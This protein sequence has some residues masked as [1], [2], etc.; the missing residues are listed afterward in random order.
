MVISGFCAGARVGSAAYEPGAG[1]TVMSYSG[2]CGA[3]NIGDPDNYFAI[4]SVLDIDRYVN[5]DDGASCGTLVA[6]G[7]QAPQID[8]VSA[9]IT[10][11]AHTPFTLVGS[12]SDPDDDPIKYSWQQYNRGP[13]GHPN[14]PTGNAP[15]FRVLPSTS[16]PTRTFPALDDVLDNHQQIGELLPAYS[17]NMRFRLVARDNQVPQGLAT[18]DVIVHVAGDA[19]PL[20]VLQPDRSTQVWTVGST[21]TIVWD[22][23]G[24]DAAPIDC[25]TVNID[26]S[27]DGGQHFAV[28]LASS[29]PNNGNHNI[30]VPNTPT[31]SARL[32][33][34]CATHP[35]HF[36]FAIAAAEFSIETVRGVTNS[37]PTGGSCLVGY[38]T[39]PTMLT[40]LDD[41]F[42]ESSQ[43]TFSWQPPETDDVIHLQISRDPT[44]VDDVINFRPIPTTSYQLP[45]ERALDLDTTYY[46]RIRVDE[47]CGGGAWSPPQTF[48][49]WQPELAADT[50]DGLVLWLDGNDVDGDFSA[51]T[52]HYDL[53]PTWHDKSVTAGDAISA[54]PPYAGQQPN[55]GLGQVE[56]L[57][58]SYLL[59]DSV[60]TLTNTI[61][62]TIFAVLAPSPQTEGSLIALSRSTPTD[63]V[64]FGLLENGTEIGINATSN[65]TGLFSSNA[66][67]LSAP[68]LRSDEWLLASYSTSEIPDS[69]GYRSR[70]AL[71]GQTVA[72]DS[73][74][75]G[76]GDSGGDRLAVGGISADVGDILVFDRQLTATE[77]QQV[78]GY[79]AHKW[80]LADRLPVGHPYAENPHLISAATSRLLSPQ[81]PLQSA[82]FCRVG[83]IIG[84]VS[85]AD[86]DT[87]L[88]IHNCTR[89]W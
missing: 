60:A 43:P 78:E 9:E 22:V 55:S 56:L 44:F 35:D 48:R 8:I 82:N 59:T 28:R 67:Q 26:L 83:T 52:T 15:L 58:H 21:Q 70:L 71:F 74:R 30:N 42:W 80:H 89:Q 63:T 86:A 25:A 49:T 45:A 24:T 47:T 34:A 6:T 66:A 68:L 54:D 32:R 19:G 4:D 39:A 64:S 84:T 75:V 18:R 88:N 76:L 79:L 41:A 81:Q 53:L 2:V 40:P 11:P 33:I 3:Q 69:E 38:S 50:I 77:Q 31:T 5:H 37:T 20:R 23:A 57:E 62:S 72:G 16:S 1:T 27:A 29:V 13:A 17:R 73:Q 61:T 51:D 7:N 10:I 87:P 46:W 36:F 14:Q 12:A 85:A 65:G